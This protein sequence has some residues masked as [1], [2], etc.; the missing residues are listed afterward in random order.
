MAVESASRTTGKTGNGTAHAANGKPHRN[1]RSSYAKKNRGLLSRLS[2]L[3]ARL[4]IWGAIFT[5][6]F[7]CPS[8]LEACDAQSPYICK[9]YFRA[10]DAVSP[11]LQPYY[12]RYA[13]PY[14]QVASPYYNA[15]N[16]RIVVPAR[17]YAAHY[18]APWVQ[19][20]QDFALSQWQVNGQPRL[21]RLQAVTKSRYDQAVAP[22]LARA[23]EAFG[24]YYEIARTNSLQTYYEFVLPSYNFVRP[25][26]AHSYSVASHFAVDTALPVA[27]WAWDRSNAFL[28]NTVWPQLRLVYVGSV[29]PQLVRIGERLGRYKNKAKS[30]VMPK[31]SST[32]SA[33]SEPAKSSFAKPTPQSAP[34]EQVSVEQSIAPDATGSQESTTK[35]RYPVEAP[36]PEANETE[37]DRKVRE[38]VASDLESWQEKFATQAEEGAAV[39]DERIGAI[40]QRFI[41]EKAQ[42]AGKQLLAQLNETIDTELASLRRQIVAIAQEA[43][44]D[45]QE[46]TIAAVRSAG[47]AIKEKALAVRKWREEYDNELQ[48]TVLETASEYFNILEETRSLALQKIGMKWA[49]AEG[50]S[51]HDWEKYH[52]LRQT[53]TK[54]TDELRDFVTTQP[55]LVEAQN[56]S[57][58]V[59][60]DAM[61]IA[62]A[63]AKE[64]A[65]LKEVAHWKILAGD[66][67][68]N[69]DSAAMKVAAEAAEKASRVKATLTEAQDQAK[70]SLESVGNQGM[71]SAKNLTG[72]VADEVSHAASSLAHTASDAA[73]S[74]AEKMSEASE[75]LLKSQTAADPKHSKDA[76]ADGQDLQDAA[77]KAPT[78]PEDTVAPPAEAK[79]IVLDTSPDAP[80]PDTKMAPSPAPEVKADDAVDPEDDAA[81]QETNKQREKPIARAAFGAAAQDVPKRH[82]VLDESLD[83][84]VFASAT[85][86]ARSAYTNAMSAAS[87][88][89]SSAQSIISAQVYGTPKPVHE[90]LFASVSAAYDNAVSAASQ[91]LNDA[92][93]AA[94]QGVYGKPTPT[95]DS[96]PLSWDK[97]ESMAA[98]RLNEGRLWAEIQYQSALIGLGMAAPTATPSTGA[99]KLV[100]QAK[101]NY[102]A[103]LGLAQDRYM[104]FLSAAS[105]AWSS[106]TATPTPTDVVGSAS[107]L[108]SVASESAVSVA[109]AAGESAS[110]MASAAGESA[111]SVVQAA[112]SAAQSVYSAA[113]DGVASAASAVE[114]SISSVVDAA[115]EQ[116]YLAGAAIADTWDKVVLEL[117]AQVYSEPTPIGWYD[118]VVGNIGSRASAATATIASGASSMT[119]VASSAADEA[120]AKAAKQYEAMSQMMSEL[121]S[122]REPAFSESVLSRFGAI[123]A[124]ASA[125]L[126]SMASEASVAASS[127]GDKVG[128]A[129]SRATDAVKDTVEHAKDEL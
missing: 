8:S 93:G 72:V 6:L 47:V 57:A 82:P 24:P 18:G 34:T 120:S 64:L 108:A 5:I 45:A 13:A 111:S 109:A 119:D 92:V 101:M 79:T 51:Y 106:V 105:S 75:Q 23:G 76:S 94:S 44:E 86:A 60:D 126:G 2:S 53:L 99:E 38:M 43:P 52:E 33:S 74:A 32:H 11:H 30:K 3:F 80:L 59:E 56:A 29:E 41:D 112:G 58:N 89:Y 54:W 121:V 39:N 118:Q 71:L 26:A 116:V 65:R 128:S 46:K 77:S 102:Y 117:S 35:T 22:H 88:Q 48:T 90:Q 125:S 91:K 100:E 28:E 61:A 16:S 84:D 62:S 25:Y 68:D 9:H 114:G 127:L 40:A 20:G 17:T 95:S 81:A 7:R 87:A 31:P 12:D 113:T 27:N 50:V 4:A 15:V 14:V 63:A 124:T 107:S 66:S 70:S 110:S 104:N 10:K 122:G 37:E 21:A 115:S 129:A 97:I 69:F 83:G 49:W 1:N 67:T 55:V 36:S 103:G 42:I 123:Y 98:Q 73:L 78:S 85:D 19:K 96:K